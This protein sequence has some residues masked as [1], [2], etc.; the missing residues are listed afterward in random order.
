MKLP[1]TLSS[2]CMWLYFLCVA[3]RTFVKV[4]T[5]ATVAPILEGIFAIGYFVFT[6]IGR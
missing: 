6:L 3:T 1:K 5:V 2:W 4:D